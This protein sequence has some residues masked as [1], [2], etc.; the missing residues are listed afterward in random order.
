MGIPEQYYK[1]PK[2]ALQGPAYHL[3]QHYGLVLND[4]KEG[5]KLAPRFADAVIRHKLL[6]AIQKSSVTG[7]RQY[8]SSNAFEQTK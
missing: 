1:I 6:D 8:L 2:H 3:A 7:Q 5:T 4:L